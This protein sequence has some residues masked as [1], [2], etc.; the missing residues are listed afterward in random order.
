MLLPSCALKISIL[1][2]L[3]WVVGS[4]VCVSVLLLHQICAIH[5]DILCYFCTLMLICYFCS[6]FFARCWCYHFVVII[7]FLLISHVFASRRFF[8]SV[9]NK[10]S[11]LPPAVQQGS[12]LSDAKGDH[13]KVDIT[14][15]IRE[16][17]EVCVLVGMFLH[18]TQCLHCA[19]YVVQT[20]IGNLS[21]VTGITVCIL[22]RLT[23]NHIHYKIDM[24]LYFLFIFFLNCLEC[25]C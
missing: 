13:P 16:S 23:E 18:P 6:C 15:L 3:L 14:D 2:S 9:T 8:D 4:C 10:D 1:Y 7:C 25:A 5:A 24:F 20:S 22:L 21:R 17:N 12:N 19:G 11:P